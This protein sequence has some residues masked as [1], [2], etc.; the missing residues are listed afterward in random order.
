MLFD[1]NRVDAIIHN[2][3]NQV[4]SNETIQGVPQRHSTCLK[5]PTGGFR[6]LASRGMNLLTT[7]FWGEK[8]I[9]TQHTS[10]VHIVFKINALLASYLQI[11]SKGAGYSPERILNSPNAEAT[12][13]QS[14]RIQ[15]F[16]KPIKPCRNGIALSTLRWIPMCQGFSQFPGFCII[17]YWPN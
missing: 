15:D 9:R 5:P 14:T 16:W 3:K 6:N 1:Q 7:I 17:L 12:F 10:L 2:W 13:V 4:F 11:I 8:L